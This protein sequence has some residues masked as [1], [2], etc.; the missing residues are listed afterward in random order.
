[1]KLT[2]ASSSSWT[3]KHR[4]CT[5]R[6]STSSVGIGVGDILGSGS[7]KSRKFLLCV[8]KKQDDVMG[9]LSE[10]HFA[11]D[12]KT[13][14]AAAASASAGAGGAAAGSDVD[15]VEGVSTAAA[16]GDRRRRRGG[17]R[18]ARRRGGRRRR[19]RGQG[20]V[21]YTHLTLPTKRI[22]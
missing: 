6:T 15:D 7:F 19:G 2:S 12:G 17:R 16:R 13:A 22:V 3:R 14:A 8:R 20:A 10:L 11:E 21:S 1:M 18:R 4:A 9:L 5:A